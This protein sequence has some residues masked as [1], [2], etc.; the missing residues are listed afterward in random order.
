MRSGKVCQT[1]SVSPHLNLSR[2]SV[3]EG[4]FTTVLLTAWDPASFGVYDRL[5][6]A[7]RSIAVSEA[8]TCDWSHLPTYWAHLRSIAAELATSP[9]S[10]DVA[11]TPRR[12]EMALMNLRSP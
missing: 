9:G 11:W 3:A 6:Y 5:V 2:D 1:P 7:N 8:C 4:P 10:E 12:V